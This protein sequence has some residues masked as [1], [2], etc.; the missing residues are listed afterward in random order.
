MYDDQEEMLKSL[1]LLHTV[2]KAIQFMPKLCRIVYSSGP[3]L[4]SFEKKELRDLI[5]PAFHPGSFEAFHHVI[6]AI[7]CEQFTSIREFAV[8]PFVPGAAF[9]EQQFS[10]E[11]FRFKDADHLEAGKFFF[12]NLH[13]LHLDVNISI[14]QGGSS[15]LDNMARLL[16]E[17]TELRELSLHLTPWKQREHSMYR[18]VS[19]EEPIFP[20]LGLRT[21]WT[22]LRMLS[23][24]GVYANE[25][26]FKDLVDRHRYTLKSLR[27]ELCGLT[28]GNW[29]HIVDEVVLTTSIPEFSLDRVH[30]VYLGYNVSFEDV[31]DRENWWFDGQLMVNEKGERY[32]EEPR[33]ENK[34]AYVWPH[35]R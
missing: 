2:A 25:G 23:I 5:P 35:G 16:C 9:S 31:H 11:A 29:T 34:K 12:H 22:S 32:F 15:M 7:H 3:R 33:T 28:E 13:K 21:T 6:G 17:T 27:F 30:D 20:R 10:L 4:Q 1:V 24:G 26:T 19:P 8:A 14:G 18:H